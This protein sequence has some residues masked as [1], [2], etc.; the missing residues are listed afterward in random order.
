MITAHVEVF[1]TS[2]EK[3]V[4]LATATMDKTGLAFAN[5]RAMRVPTVEENTSRYVATV[6]ITAEDREA[7]A[8][9]LRQHFDTF[10]LDGTEAVE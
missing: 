2:D 10:T 6:E 8:E 4:A 3:A 7:V 1:A 9:V 5:V